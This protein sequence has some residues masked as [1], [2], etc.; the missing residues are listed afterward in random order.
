MKKIAILL[1]C[2]GAFQTAIAQDKKT[3]KSETIII[4]ENKDDQNGSTKVEIRDGE[5]FIDGKKVE[6]GD[7]GKDGSVKIYRKKYIN[8][9]EV[10][11]DDS[12]VD[13]FS[14][15][16]DDMEM[17]GSKPMLGVTFKQSDS[18]EG[19]IVES[20]IPKSPAEQM[21][22][23]AGDVITK[24]DDKNI[25]TP[26][27]LVETISGYKPGD[28][29]NITFE[30]GSNMMTKKAT[31]DKQKNNF[32]FNRTMPFGEDLFSDMNPFF[33]Q[34][35]FNNENFRRGPNSAPSPKI[36]VS[37]EDRADGEG[38]LVQD[39]TENSVAEKG[40]IEKGDVITTFGS[41]TIQNVDDLME[42][43]QN[44][45]T[46]TKVELTIKRKGVTKKL[47]LNM[48]KVLKKKDL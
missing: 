19:A 15:P 26:K 6:D 28:Q 35:G 31:L 32:T 33:K 27:D 18:N 20:V 9:K 22:I 34:F 24:V 36:G 25:L 41:S 47:E 12:D 1:V 44:N 39:V 8:G 43:I 45:Q 2:F 23:K 40:G 30:R 14:S 21:G 17:G 46:K 42:A 16:F 29:V 4:Q 7:R 37:A 48:P 38:V 5:V 13:I 11:F 10:P 3:Q